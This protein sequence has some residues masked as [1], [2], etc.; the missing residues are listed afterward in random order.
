MKVEATRRGFYDFTLWREGD[1]FELLDPRDFA[2]TWMVEVDPT[3]RERRQSVQEAIDAPFV[4]RHGVRPRDVRVSEPVE[5]R[6]EVL[7]DGDPYP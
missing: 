5:D 7:H 4:E 6:D 2:P 1:R 3:T